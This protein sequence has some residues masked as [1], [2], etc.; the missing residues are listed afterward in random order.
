MADEEALKNAVARGAIIIDVRA[1]QGW[2]AEET[3]ES[4]VHR[5]VHLPWNREKREMELVGL[6]ADKHAAIIVHCARGARAEAARQFLVAQGYTN[7]LN[8]GGPCFPGLWAIYS[9]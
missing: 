7:V 2:G 5:A 3:K 6:P 1:D 8:G 9:Q 4:R